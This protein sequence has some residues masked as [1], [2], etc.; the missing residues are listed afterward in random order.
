MSILQIF[1]EMN[2]DPTHTLGYIPEGFTFCSETLHQ[3]V[4]DR[5]DPECVDPK[6][7]LDALGR[8]LQE[9]IK[10]VARTANGT[11]KKRKSSAALERRVGPTPGIE[12]AVASDSP[13]LHRR[14]GI[15]LPAG[16]TKRQRHDKI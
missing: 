11:S 6:Q 16:R 15:G 8:V 13:F 2:Q 3:T 1:L 7:V 14:F 4:L 9:A 12:E 5:L 10:S